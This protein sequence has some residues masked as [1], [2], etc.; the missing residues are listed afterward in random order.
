MIN[1]A[2]RSS[3]QERLEFLFDN[4]GAGIG[5]TYE[6]TTYKVT[7]IT[8]YGESLILTIDDDLQNPPEDSLIM[9]KKAMEGYDLVIGKFRQKKHNFTSFQAP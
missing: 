7:G 2:D 5:T 1:E 9:L 4:S 6:A 8:N 3:D